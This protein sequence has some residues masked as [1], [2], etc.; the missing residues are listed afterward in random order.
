MLS[1]YLSMLD[2]H[3]DKGFI[4]RL[5]KEYEQELF[6]AAYQILK[7]NSDAEDAVHEA[8]LSAVKNIHKLRTF[9]C[10]E[11]RLYMIVIVRNAAKRIYNKGKPFARNTVYKILKNEKYAGIYRHNDEIFTNMYPAIV[12]AEIYNIVRKKID[13]NKYGKRSTETVYLLKHKLKC[14]YCGMPISAECGTA[15][16]GQKKHY[17]KLY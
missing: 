15:S 1:V 17:Y 5:Y 4:E 3:A 2:T 13:Q 8:F 6:S 12:S 10:H 9:S 7:N 11:L 14:G 16:N